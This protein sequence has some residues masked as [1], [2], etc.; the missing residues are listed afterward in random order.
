MKYFL[1]NKLII[2]GFFINIL[3]LNLLSYYSKYDLMKRGYIFFGKSDNGIL[4]IYLKK[5]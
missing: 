5:K 4:H 2:L 1:N 3:N